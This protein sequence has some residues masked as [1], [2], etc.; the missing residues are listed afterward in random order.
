MKSLNSALT[1]VILCSLGGCETSGPKENERFSG[2]WRLD[3]FEAMDSRT[4]TWADDST[5]I[6]WS[7]YILYDGQGH[8]GVHLTPK[9][10]QDFDTRKN[11][12][13]LTHDELKELATFY[14]SNF[15]YFAEY[16]LTD[17]TIEHKRLSATE[18]QNWGKSLT[19]TFEF[20]QDTLL[21]TAWEAIEGQRVRLRW[22]RLQ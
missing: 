9:A 6:G 14:K 3:K 17:S 21:L 16:L 11:I 20:R 7:G 5:K 8:M 10:Y 2:M 13:S 12:D 15:V 18:P 1:L 22:I 19:R 4:N